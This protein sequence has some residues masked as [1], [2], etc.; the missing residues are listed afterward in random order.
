MPAFCVKAEATNWTTPVQRRGPISTASACSRPSRYARVTEFALAA[1]CF[2]SASGRAGR[3]DDVSTYPHARCS[4]R[5][6]R[7]TILPALPSRS[8]RSHRHTRYLFPGLP[9]VEEK[10]ARPG[11]C[12][13]NVSDCV[14]TFRPLSPEY[15]VG[16]ES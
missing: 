3:R 15:G 6:L 12:Y 11:E 1:A 4:L 10:A 9:P 13:S 14:A 7:R 2:L 16:S 5:F 8:D